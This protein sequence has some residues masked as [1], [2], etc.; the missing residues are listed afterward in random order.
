LGDGVGLAVDLQPD[1]HL[2]GIAP[3]CGRRDNCVWGF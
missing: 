3:G 1:A 2:G